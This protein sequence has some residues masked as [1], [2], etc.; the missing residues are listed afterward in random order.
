VDSR[1]RNG[2]ISDIRGTW[3]RVGVASLCIES[4]PS[5]VSFG[6]GFQSTSTQIASQIIT[7]TRSTSETWRSWSYTPYLP[8]RCRPLRTIRPP[9]PTVSTELQWGERRWGAFGTHARVAGS[10]S[11]SVWLV[12]LP[13]GQPLVLA[14]CGQLIT[15]WQHFGYQR[16]VGQ[17]GSSKSLYQV[18]AIE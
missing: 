13:S 4:W 8:L 10:F 12:L 9:P 18:L 14:I 2:S 11:I 3:G 17:G 15:K 5:N 6:F 7:Q 1:S 16:N